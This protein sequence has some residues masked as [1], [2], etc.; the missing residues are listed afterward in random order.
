MARTRTMR[1]RQK[2]R[3]RRT[4]TSFAKKVN[5]V[6]VGKKEKKYLIQGLSGTVTTTGS[7][8]S[9]DSYIVEGDDSVNRDGRV[10][11]MKSV[12]FLGQFKPGDDYNVIRYGVV[13]SR[14]GPIASIGTLFE[15]GVA[16]V[17]T[18]LNTQKVN[19]LYDKYVN[20]TY[21]AWDG[22]LIPPTYSGPNLH[23]QNVNIPISKRLQYTDT[24]GSANKPIY[25][26]VL[27]DS[28]AAPHVEYLG[29]VKI[30]FYDV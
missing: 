22:V 4:K 3:A 6:L 30:K 7:L 19:I 9:L 29:N 28:L 21:N 17:N 20:M 26:F 16:G 18:M 13:Q 1:R 23:L 14:I 12:R 8:V 11:V 5:K 10:C 27:S 25:Y 15:G 2:R 24:T